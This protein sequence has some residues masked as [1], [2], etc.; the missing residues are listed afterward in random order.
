M[1]TFKSLREKTVDSILLAYTKLVRRGL[2]SRDFI[3]VVTGPGMFSAVRSG[4][5]VTNILAAISGAKLIA[6][7]RP[8]LARAL[9]MIVIPSLR[10]YSQRELHK[11]WKIVPEFPP[12]FYP[13]GGVAI[14]FYEKGPSITRPKIMP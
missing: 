5:V 11:L 10:G 2:S 7:D 14:P 3:L 9:G 8:S 6:I 13:K 4:V 12:S 1:K